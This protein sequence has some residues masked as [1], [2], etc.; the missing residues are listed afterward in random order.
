M[1]LP[2]IISSVLKGGLGNQLFQIACGLAIAKK[3]HCNFVIDTSLI[4][5]RGQGS[6]PEKYYTNLFQKIMVSDLSKLQLNT[7][8]YKEMGFA[9]QN[10]V[11]IVSDALQKWGQKIVLEGY[12]QSDK[13]FS[14]FGSYIY[15]AF[16][17]EIGLLETIRKDT[18]LFLRFPELDPVK[19]G[20]VTSRCLVGVRRGDY[21]KDSWNVSFHN[22][23]GL[24]YYKKAFDL[25]D[26]HVYYVISDD[27]DWC[28]KEFPREFPTKSFVFLEEPDDLVTFYFARLFKNYICANSSFH[29]WASYLS[30]Y[31]GLEDIK[32]ICPKTHFGPNGPQDYQDYFRKDMILL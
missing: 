22:P 4:G 30:Y 29:W 31:R 19:V 17:P 24:D 6:H 7:F 11:P 21:L 8:Y 32:V 12:F 10:L 28:K 1:N 9:W 3:C 2:P 15:D 14:E 26:V 25:V 5:E 13:Y 18:N 23:C 16:T 27:I 20:L